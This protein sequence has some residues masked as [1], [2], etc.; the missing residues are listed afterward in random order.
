MKTIKRAADWPRYYRAR[1]WVG[2]PDGDLGLATLWTPRD[3]FL[4]QL[5]QHP[6]PRLALV[7]QLYTPRGSE[8]IFRNLWLNPRV[9]TV[10][11]SGRDLTGSWQPLWQ[12]DHPL[13]ENFPAPARRQFFQ[14]VRFLDWR[15][16]NPAAVI[17]DLKKL[18]PQPPFTNHI[19]EFAETKAKTDH[20]PAA[21]SLFPFRAPTIG[22]AWLL[23]LEAI[24]RFGRRLPRIHVYGGHERI[25]LN[26]AIVIEEEDPAHPRLWPFFNFDRRLLRR[27]YRNFFQ[28]DRGEEPYTYGERLFRYQP[29]QK[30][31]NQV[32]LMAQKLRSFPYNK[33]ALA[34][35]WQPEIDNYPI[36][37][38]WRTPCL[39]LVQGFCLD[40]KLYLT[41]YF[42][43]N[44]MFAAWPLNAFALRYL[45]AGLAKKINRR[46]GSLTIIS[47]AAYIDEGDLALAEKIV[48]QN[49]RLV[50]QND[51]RGA[52]VIE[53]E[54]TDIVVRHLAP[55]GATILGQYRQDGR[56]PKAALQLAQKLLLD[57]VISRLD[58]ALDIGE[59]L[60]KAEQAIKL[61]LQFEQDRDLQAVKP[62][63]PNSGGGH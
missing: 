8:F 2:N 39:S 54:G 6:S 17:R 13:W 50:C 62:K 61:G 52:L 7:G 1:L 34:V 9:S 42:R 31:V 16:K 4:A 5:G 15:Q 29:G 32:N 48:R 28:P 10:I 19:R 59:Q 38:P 3:H 12:P 60:G 53:V 43:S 33:G 55:D 41:A 26:S 51:P 23:V 57:Q 30:M 45:Q 40:D 20:Y 44:D 49:R 63:K 46:L 35:L 18:P 58:H 36:R 37:R 22:E 21:A 14:K 56:Q 27:Y 11:I 24:L 25:I 47:Q